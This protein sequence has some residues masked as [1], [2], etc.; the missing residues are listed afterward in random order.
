[1]DLSLR[2]HFT[3]NWK[4]YFGSAELPLAFFYSDAENTA[5]AAPHAEKWNCFI[6][7]LAQVRRG[8][9]M[10]FDVNSIGCSGGKRYLGFSDKLK[11]GFEYFLSCGNE[12]ME[13]ERYLR[14]PAQVEKF[15]KANPL[16]PAP[17]SKIIFKRWDMLEASDAPEVVI[18]F[19]TPDVLSGLFTLAGYDRDDFQGTITPFGSGCASMVQYPLAESKNPKPRAILGMFD[20]SARPYIKENEFTFTLPFNRFL[21]IISYMDES[22]LI[23][24]SW[25]KV[26][27]RIDR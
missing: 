9:S 17:A 21:E 18:F 3:A 15:L 12:K 26:K 7:A 2:D 25:Q 16:T 14:T 1:M 24:P 6:G 11:P 10:A 23:T 13:G 20:V 5:E 19:A 4:K 27:S 22:F 8:K